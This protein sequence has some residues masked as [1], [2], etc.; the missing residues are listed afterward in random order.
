MSCKLK[1][2]IVTNIKRCFE[3]IENFLSCLRPLKILCDFYDAEHNFVVNFQVQTF[4][5]LCLFLLFNVIRWKIEILWHLFR[6]SSG[7]FERLQKW[8]LSRMLKWKL[9]I[10]WREFLQSACGFEHYFWWVSLW[11]EKNSSYSSSVT[12]KWV[13]EY[14][15]TYLIE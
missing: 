6:H 12:L 15:K 13:L 1:A 2:F 9:K 3:M 8:K 7:S 14:K 5:I 11:I 10:D 4:L